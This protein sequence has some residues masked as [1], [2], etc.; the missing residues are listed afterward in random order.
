[1]RGPDDAF[2]SPTRAVQVDRAGLSGSLAFLALGYFL[3]VASPLLSTRL[4]QVMSG[5]MDLNPAGPWLP[6]AAAAGVAL[7]GAAAMMLVLSRL[8]RDV[9]TRPYASVAPVLTVFTGFILMGLR[10]KLPFAGLASEHI[11]VFA[12]SLSLCGGALACRDGIGARALG[13]ALALMP[14][15]TIAFALAALTERGD[16]EAAMR[17]ADPQVRVYLI[18]LALSSLALAVL[19]SVA[20]ALA[21]SKDADESLEPPVPVLR[22]PVQQHA[23]YQPAMAMAAQAPALGRYAMPQ[24]DAYAGAPSPRYQGTYPRFDPARALLPPDFSFED[25]EEKVAPKARGLGRPAYA[26]AA[27]LAVALLA[28][29]FGVMRPRAEQA[30]RVLEAARLEAARASAQR[31]EVARAAGAEETAAA[32]ARLEALIA[33]KAAPEAAPAA[34]LPTPVAP[35]A[36]EPSRVAVA[37]APAP[38]APQLLRA[39]DPERDAARAQAKA[40]RSAAKAA[41]QAERDA[42]RAEKAKSAAAAAPA[43]PVSTNSADLDLDQLVEKAMQGG[44]NKG[45]SVSASDDPLLGL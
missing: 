17:R 20:A 23:A 25:A 34:P 38:V 30:A 39:H 4:A 18:L 27:L 43:K 40:Q 35:M 10:A 31:A 21:R 44:K 37:P 13:W 24:R 41:A 1:M 7:I 19:G 32:T 9:E 28:G 11:G 12:L 14:P 22:L 6:A 36:A 2:P 42:A 29:Y 26:V 16:V 15:V 3:I 8:V 45:G 5:P 33:G